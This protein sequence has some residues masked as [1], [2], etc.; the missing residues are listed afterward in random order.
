MNQRRLLGFTL[1]EMSL[2]LV[3]F[4]VLLGGLMQPLLNNRDQL[5]HQ[6]ALW[7][8]DEIHEALLG[9]TVSQGHMPCPSTEATAGVASATSDG[10][11][12]YGG[13]IPSVDLGVM[14]E[15]DASGILLDPWGNRLIYRL[16]DYDSDGDGGADFAVVDGMRKAGLS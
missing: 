2:V 12:A 1:L 3:V 11:S 10:C 5:L 4:A 7:Q 14:G 15:L 13:F 8:L 6:R 16:S 9:Y